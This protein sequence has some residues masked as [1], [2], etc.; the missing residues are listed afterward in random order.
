[1]G[2]VTIKDVAKAAGVS[3]QT[4][5]RVINNKKELTQETRGRVL[6][7]ID[8]MGYRPNTLAR[9]LVSQRSHTIGVT[10]PDIV[11]PF[12]AEIVLGIQEKAQELGYIALQISTTENLDQERQILNRLEENQ[13]SGVISISSR[14][15]EDELVSLF[16]RQDAVVMINR[17]IAHSDCG[18]ITTDNISGIQMGVSHLLNTHRHTIAHICGPSHSWNGRERL[19]GYKQALS[20]AGLP[21]EESLM[22]A[23]PPE[24][25]ETSHQPYGHVMGAIDIGEI[26]TRQLFQARPDVDAIIC[27]NDLLAI[28]A[29]RACQTLGIDVP[30]QVSIVGFDN[31]LM[32]QLIT[33]PLTTLSISKYGMGAKAAEMVIQKAE[34]GVPLEKMTMQYELVVRGSTQS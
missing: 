4:V 20:A 27:F 12:F 2:S 7:V 9:S 10:I 31:I 5:S 16:K 6:Q 22:L 14:L 1:M 15:P 29:I 26:Q 17:S 8:Q 19:D 34:A 30:R 28:G 24:V 21:I 11:N 3:I 23:Y 18:E 13:V 33:P 25:N 32:G